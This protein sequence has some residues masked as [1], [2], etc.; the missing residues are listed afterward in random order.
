MKFL[1]F[2]GA[3]AALS[4]VSI[5]AKAEDTN[6]MKRL[7]VA[8]VEHG[9]TEFKKCL[10][11]HTLERNADHGAGP[12]LWG[13][14]HR[15]VATA[16]DYDYSPAFKKLSG[17]WTATRLDDYL[18][19]PTE[20]AKGTNMT[21][22]GIKKPSQRANLIAYINQNSDLIFNFAALSQD[23]SGD[24]AEAPD[25]ADDYGVLFVA[26]GVEETHAYCTACHSERIV[27]QQGLTRDG[28]VE[29]LEWM[30]DEQ[31]MG[32]IDEPDLTLVLDYL[33]ANYNTD[34]PNFPR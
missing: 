9:K 29:L 12:N 5:P 22:V 24:E 1:S 20:H 18:E 19:K 32:E 16:K 23:I 17:K 6:I 3:I 31:D 8:N 21:F 25:D 34:R 28:W 30:V 11:C 7:A 10:Q 26:K 13:V 33:A 14:M 2:I 4:L 15:D 27:A